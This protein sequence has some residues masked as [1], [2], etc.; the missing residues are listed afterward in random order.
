M[1]AGFSFI[2]ASNFGDHFHNF[3]PD[4]FVITTQHG[5]KNIF[6]V[7]KIAAL[8]TLAARKKRWVEKS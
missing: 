4:Y 8:C 2:I 6:G 5:E 1:I 3:S 7:G